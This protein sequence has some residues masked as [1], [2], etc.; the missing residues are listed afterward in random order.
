M[1]TTGINMLGVSSAWTNFVLGM[2]LMLS[3]FAGKYLQ[4]NQIKIKKGRVSHG[5]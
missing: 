3:L 5:C 1:I 2:I 4:F